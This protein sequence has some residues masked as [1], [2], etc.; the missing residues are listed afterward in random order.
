MAAV[1]TWTRRY[2]ALIRAAWLVDLQYG[3]T[4]AIWLIWGVLE[5]TIALGIWWSIARGGAVQGYGQADFARYFFGV[6]LVNALTVAWDAWYID[7]WIRHGEMNYRLARPLS[8]IHEAIADNVAYKVRTGSVILAAWLVAAAV[9][10]AVRLPLDPGR[11]AVAAVAVVLAAGI[12]FF[13]GYATGL[14]AFWTTRATALVDLQFGVSLFLAGRI[15]PLRLLPAAA[16]RVASVLW[17]P[18]MLAF[19]VD[20]LTGGVTTPAACIRGLALQ[21][22]WLAIWWGLYRLIWWRGLRHYGAVG[23]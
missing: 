1:A 20:V 16:Q 19:P 18:S 3:A 14:L 4:I 9:W 6:T 15:A 8:P 23:G 17:F 12:R 11:W 13:N 2:G 10:P 5:P 22:L 7:R 21:V